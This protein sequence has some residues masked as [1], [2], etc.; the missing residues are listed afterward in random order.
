[1]NADKDFN[2]FSTIDVLKV[3]SLMGFKNYETVL[4]CDIS[5]SKIFKVKKWLSYGLTKQEAIKKPVKVKRMS[6]DQEGNEPKRSYRDVTSNYPKI[7]QH[8][9]H[10]ISYLTDEGTSSTI[11]CLYEWLDKD[12]TTKNIKFSKLEPING[13]IKIN[14]KNKETVEWLN[15]T[16]QNINDSLQAS[17]VVVD[18]TDRQKCQ[19]ITI[20]I[21]D[22]TMTSQKLFMRLQKQNDGLLTVHWNTLKTE[23]HKDGDAI[24]LIEIDKDSGDYIKNHKMRLDCGFSEV[25]VRFER[26]YENKMMMSDLKDLQMAGSLEESLNMGEDSK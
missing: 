14:C 24:W 7:I 10:P 22:P 26:D 16:V 23:E 11:N 2:D 25:Y 1:M 4:T 12:Q 19:Y 21:G 3:R 5:S 17:L 13:I 18:G 9:E 6:E 20:K 15:K 8:K